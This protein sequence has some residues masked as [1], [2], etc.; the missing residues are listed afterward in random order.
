MDAWTTPSGKTNK[1]GN[2]YFKEINGGPVSRI[3]YVLFSEQLKFPLFDIYAF[4]SSPTV[5]ITKKNI[6]SDHLCLYL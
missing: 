4:Q 6:Y 3:D 1:E 2:T 5:R